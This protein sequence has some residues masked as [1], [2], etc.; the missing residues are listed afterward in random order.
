MRY[1]YTCVWSCDNT[2][3]KLYGFFEMSYC[4]ALPLIDW[5]ALRGIRMVCVECVSEEV[6]QR[7]G[8]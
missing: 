4:D 1:I 7:I 2:P 3:V 6:T 8:A 5:F